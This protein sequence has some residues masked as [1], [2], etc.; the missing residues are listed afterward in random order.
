M[1]VGW[2]DTSPPGPQV[3]LTPQRAAGRGGR[4][5]V[6]Q[7]GDGSGWR[8]ADIGTLAGDGVGLQPGVQVDFGQPVYVVPVAGPA[9]A[10]GCGWW[11]LRSKQLYSASVTLFAPGRMND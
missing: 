1:F 6:V 5:Y 7:R 2:V 8:L 4:L 11:P 3:R 10:V 9:S